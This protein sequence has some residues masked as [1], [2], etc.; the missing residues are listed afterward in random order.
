MMHHSKNRIYL[1]VAAV[2]VL[3]LVGWLLFRNG[4]DNNGIPEPVAG[5][6]ITVLGEITCLPYH[7]NVAGQDCVKGI[8]GV[9]GKIYA[10]NSPKALERAFGEGEDVTAVGIYEP[11]NTSFDDSSVF[12]YDAV[13]V[14]SK[15]EG[16]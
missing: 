15:L 9:D 2:A 16:R 8:L 14:L 13:L 6:E 12:D 3:L 4:S 7:I 11:A 10:L 1:A 5:Q